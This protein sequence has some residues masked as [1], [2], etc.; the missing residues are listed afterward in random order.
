MGKN[1]FK[2]K[3]KLLDILQAQ[4]S[5]TET[6]EIDIEQ[7]KVLKWYSTNANKGT[8]KPGAFK[9]ITDTEL[10]ITNSKGRVIKIPLETLGQDSLKLA[11]KLYEAT[12]KSV[13]DEA[14]NAVTSSFVY[15]QK[16]LWKSASGGK[17]VE[18][19]YI[20][21][22]D[23]DYLTLEVEKFGQAP[24]QVKLPLDKLDPDSQKKAKDWKKTLAEQIEK[25]AAAKQE[26]L[27]KLNS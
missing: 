3:T 26:A 5:Y 27:D 2:D 1:D 7:P 15:P 11:T 17:T 25:E 14:I 18:A 22:D 21:L 24:K 6:G 23:M 13:V 19:K 10:H 8:Y 12:S 9:S 16:D 4:K 20:S